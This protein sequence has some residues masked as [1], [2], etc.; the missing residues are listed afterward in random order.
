M[1]NLSWFIYLTQVVDNV[2][3]AAA[4]TLLLGGIGG[5]LIVP[6]FLSEFFDCEPAFTKKVLWIYGAAMVLAAMVACFTPSRQTML[7][8]A[9]SEMGERFVKSETVNSVV[10]PG[11][12][13][14][15]TWIKRET[16]KLAKEASK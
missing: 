12:D 9:G 16:E 13:L 2:G 4:I 11:V 15:K 1:N 10:N 3:T 14:L 6:I 7:L 8:I 5:L